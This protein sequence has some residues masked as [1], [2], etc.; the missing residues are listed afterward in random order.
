MCHLNL[1]LHNAGPVK[2][3]R[4]EELD[5]K[6]E[7][8]G[9]T[10]LMWA[11]KGGYYDCARLLYENGASIDLT[12]DEGKTGMCVCV[13]VC[14]CKCVSTAGQERDDEIDVVIEKLGQEAIETQREVRAVAVR[15]HNALCYAHH[16]N[17]RFDSARI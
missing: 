15:R 11:C 1:N 7:D 17:Q 5:C 6:D 8:V 13:C 10:A 4:Y 9:L 2:K 3:K 12:S 16:R 14:V